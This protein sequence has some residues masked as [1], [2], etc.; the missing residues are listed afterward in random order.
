MVIRGLEAGSSGG[1][2][3]APAAAHRDRLHLQ[4]PRTGRE[5]GKGEAKGAGLGTGTRVPK[6]H[7]R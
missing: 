6:L 4:K 2:Q 3:T 1:H 7:G 5:D